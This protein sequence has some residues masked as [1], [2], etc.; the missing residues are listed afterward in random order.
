[1]LASLARCFS[2]IAATVAGRELVAPPRPLSPP[3]LLFLK[4]GSELVPRSPPR[5][6][7]PPASSIR[8]GAPIGTFVSAMPPR[9]PPRFPPYPPRPAAIGGSCAALRSTSCDETGKFR[10]AVTSRWRN[11][12]HAL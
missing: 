11:A 6:P 1:M 3:S 9:E 4:C 5:E 2:P 10:G 12:P 7:T 8:G